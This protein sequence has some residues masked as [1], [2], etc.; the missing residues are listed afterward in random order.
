MTTALSRRAAVAGALAVPFLARGAAAQA[1]ATV[2]FAY[3]ADPSHEAVLWALR[4][5]KVSS[6]SVRVDAT[7]LDISAL[8]QATAAR[9]YDVVQTAAV[10]IPRARERGLDLKIVGTGLRY[11]ASGEG[12]G[13][14]VKRGS[15]IASANDLKG[16]KL[17]V[18]SIGSA[19]IT[20]IRIAL[21]DVY[22]LNMSARGGDLELVE[23][24]APALPAALA[25]GRIDAATLIH[26]QAFQAQRSGDF[27]GVIQTAGD[28]TRRFGTRMVSA[29]LA[30]YGDK[31]SAEPARYQEL[32][33]VLRASMEY[34]L[35][36]PDEVFTAVG[37]ATQTDP[38]FFRAWF[39]RYSE[40]PV[41]LTESDSRAIELLWRRASEM[42]WM[43]GRLPPA[44]EAFWSGAIRS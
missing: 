1:A 40:F 21:Q 19:G 35:A 26:T 38:D 9:T 12:A 11:H 18:Y 17:G 25:T 36:N 33:R 29:V 43:Q 16:K 8:I 4:N 20:L 37:T 39:T 10:A 31:L 30:G 7:P 32:L 41:T 15:P 44:A 24:P 23:M 34:A 3:L 42:G 14:W 13:I 22:G 2:T 5:G 6:P 28:M 27:V